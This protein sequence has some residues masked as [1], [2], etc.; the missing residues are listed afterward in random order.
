M[1]SWFVQLFIQSSPIIVFSIPIMLRICFKHNRS[2]LTG[3]CQCAYKSLLTFLRKT[4]RLKD[5]IPGVV[6]AI[7]TFGECPEKFHPHIHA[8]VTDRLF[9]DTGLFHVMKKRF[10]IIY[11]LLIPSFL[12]SWSM[13]GEIPT[14][15]LLLQGVCTWRFYP[16]DIP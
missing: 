9:A 14:S 13:S 10:L 3:L 15:F 16:G 7:H 6:M 8:I 1:T 5:G 12:L 11:H 4:V 2:L